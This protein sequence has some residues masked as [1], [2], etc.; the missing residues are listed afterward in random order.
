MLRKLLTLGYILL[1]TLC[2]E[3]GSA[4]EWVTVKRVNDGDTVQLADRRFVRYI[5]VNAPEI[6]HE[7][8]TAE[9]FGFEARF[10]RHTA[11][12]RVFYLLH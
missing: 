2:A 5:G 4:A 12:Y 3:A 10:F 9:P 7:R 6:N 1:L 11:S 8:N